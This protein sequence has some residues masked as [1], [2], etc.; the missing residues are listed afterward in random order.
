MK[1]G[2]FILDSDNVNLSLVRLIEPLLFKGYSIDLFAERHDKLSVYAFVP[3]MSRLKMVDT[4]TV[5]LLEAYNFVV[6]GRNCFD[7]RDSSVLLDFK[8]IIFADDT[9]FYEGNSVFGDVIFVSGEQGKENIP[10]VLDV[11]VFQVGCLKADYESVVQSEIWKKFVTYAKK[12]LYIESGH[13]PFGTAGRR[14]LAGE[15][16]R[17]VQE[18]PDYGFV[19]K[20]RYLL[21]ECNG[22]KH[23]NGDHLYHYIY[24]FF[25]SHIPDN[26]LLLERHE[27][28]DGLVSGADIVINTYSSAHSEAVLAGKRLI[29][30]TGIPSEEIADFRKNRFA[31]VTRVI[32]QAG[33]NMDIFELSDKIA[34]AKTANEQ[35]RNYLQ[36]SKGKAIENAVD[37]FEKVLNQGLNRQKVKEQRRLAYRLKQLSIFENR[38]DNY[39]DFQKAIVKHQNITVDEYFKT[40]CSE[41]MDRLCKNLFDRAFILR[42][43]YKKREIQSCLRIIENTPNKDSAC[44]FYYG[45]ICDDQEALRR[46]VKCYEVSLYDKTDA[47]NYENYMYARRL[48]L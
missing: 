48:I 41:N 45:I 14:I 46:Y 15:F 20:P 32:D 10:D 36:S 6:C 5:E 26:L 31:Q 9:G 22:G 47:D 39:N 3:Y 19:L 30:L 23:R 24:R 2:L 42:F 11:P 21:D 29:N 33:C 43:F 40:Y 4:L 37:V 17:A 38:L 35:Y 25:E 28:M 7:I 1:K 13:Y 12:V 34:S 27:R 16:C 8:G 44:D 18:H